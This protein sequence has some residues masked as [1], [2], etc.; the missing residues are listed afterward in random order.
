MFDKPETPEIPPMSPLDINAPTILGLEKSCAGAITI[1]KNEGAFLPRR[2]T[3]ETKQN[4][5]NWTPGNGA[6]VPEIYKLAVHFIQEGRFIRATHDR[7]EAMKRRHAADQARKESLVAE[8]RELRREAMDLTQPEVASLIGEKINVI[9]EME[10]RN[11]SYYATKRVEGILEA[12]KALA[13]L[14]GKGPKPKATPK[15]EAPA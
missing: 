15:G 7:N 11:G 3:E 5:L 9:R 2:Y 1:W 12:Y 8:M 10:G 14:K 6:Y 4:L 13:K